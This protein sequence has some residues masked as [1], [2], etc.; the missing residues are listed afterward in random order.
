MEVGPAP[1]GRGAALFH[2]LITHTFGNECHNRLNRATDRRNAT[3]Q[4]PNDWPL[5]GCER[6]PG[7]HG[8]AS[9]VRLR[10]GEQPGG[11]ALPGLAWGGQ[12][13][14]VSVQVSVQRAPTPPAVPRR[15]PLQQGGTG[16]A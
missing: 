8:S 3:I 6:G 15:G 4:P 16:T 14:C 10:L 11:D 13:R 2:S 7:G 1:R 12:W 9:R 5:P